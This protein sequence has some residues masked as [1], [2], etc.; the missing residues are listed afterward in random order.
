MVEKDTRNFCVI[1]FYCS[2]RRGHS[3][4]YGEIAATE[5]DGSKKG[6]DTHKILRCIAINQVNRVLPQ[7]C[8][9]KKIDHYDCFSALFF[10]TLFRNKQVVAQIIVFFIA[11]QQCGTIVTFCFRLK[12]FMGTQASARRTGANWSEK[13]NDVN[14][15]NHQ[16]FSTHR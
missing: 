15:V 4:H 3:F 11:L 10:N 5:N 6:F 14:V 2:D 8:I 16:F 1:P 12:E 9:K 7:H 13:E